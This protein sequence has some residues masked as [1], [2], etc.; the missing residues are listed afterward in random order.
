M[1]NLKNQFIEKVA[2]QIVE[3]GNARNENNFI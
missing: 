2:L 1:G 3:K